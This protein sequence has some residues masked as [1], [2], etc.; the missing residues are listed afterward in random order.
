MYYHTVIH[1]LSQTNKHSHR[2]TI[3]PGN[4][5]LRQ[6]RSQV[7]AEKAGGLGVGLATLPCSN[8]IA[9]E[10][11]NRIT[12]DITDLAESGPPAGGHM[13]P[14]SE[15]QCQLEA[16]RLKTITPLGPQPSSVHGMS[17][18]CTRP[19]GE[20]KWLQRLGSSSSPSKGSVN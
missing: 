2:N 16:I 11:P 19:E 8:L 4:T 5:Q 14:D 15:S 10:M 3:P 13:T 6:G 18:P 1:T 7:R 17:E 12:T 20:H 9:T